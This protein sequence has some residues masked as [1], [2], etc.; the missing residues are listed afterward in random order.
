[1]TEKTG[2]FVATHVDGESAVL[3][4]VET[5]QVHTLD[6]SPSFPAGTVIEGTIA[7]TP[8]MEVVWE[9]QTIDDQRQIE[10]VETELSPTTQ[11]Q[12]AV[13]DEQPGT[14]TR[15]EREGDGELHVLRVPD[16]E[17]A[18]TVTEVLEDDETV[19]RAARLGAI[20][21]ELRAG[22]GVVSVRYLPD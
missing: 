14:V 13:A 9:L 16:G 3:Q 21:V 2:T 1:M 20:R 4:D 7:A 22:D 18:A 12:E 8:P 5:A 10:L 17:E 19:A 15:I 6:E 11:A